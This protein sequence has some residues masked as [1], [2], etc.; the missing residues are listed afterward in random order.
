MIPV[1]RSGD[2]PGLRVQGSGTHEDRP[3]ILDLLQHVRIGLAAISPAGRQTPA[4]ASF[5]NRLLNP[6]HLS[7]YENH[8][9]ISSIL[10][11]Q[12]VCMNTRVD[13]K[14]WFDVKHVVTEPP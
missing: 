10:Q 11:A 2:Y 4:T 1:R 9:T 8:S 7:S 5:L 14:A 3:V 13:W 12:L 6:R